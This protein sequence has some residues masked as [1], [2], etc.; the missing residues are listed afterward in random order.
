M[1]S[2]GTSIVPA[3]A[4]P[5]A[6]GHAGPINRRYGTRRSQ[7]QFTTLPRP[8]VRTDVR[9]GPRSNAGQRPAPIKTAEA[10][11]PERE[12]ALNDFAEALARIPGLMGVS[13]LPPNGFPRCTWLPGSIYRAVDRS[14]RR[15]PRRRAHSGCGLGSRPAAARQAGGAISH[16]VRLAAWPVEWWIL[17]R[18]ATGS[19]PSGIPISGRV[20]GSV[21]NYHLKFTWT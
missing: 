13:W 18:P 17:P 3:L 4:P 12:S 5:A 15:R 19:H 20:V 21:E 7:P 16:L 6:R 14:R 8:C 9:P 11:L 1:V 10:D 2:V